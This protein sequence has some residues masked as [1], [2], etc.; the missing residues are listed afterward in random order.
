VNDDVVEQAIVALLDEHTV[1][2]LATTHDAAP[3]AVSLMYARDG[4]AL[5]WVSDPETRHSR[6]LAANPRAAATVARQYEDFT[7]IRGLQMTGRARRLDGGDETAWALDLL[8]ERYPFFERFRA[9][10]AK[11]ARHL[12]AAAAYRFDPETVTLVDNTRGFGF[13]AEITPKSIS[14]RS[15]G[16][17]AVRKCD[18]STT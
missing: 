1:F 12:E 16:R 15:G 9:G 6:D 7:S 18:Q 17:F 13:R 8:T 10:P 11:L 5:V 3:H 14:R 2:T 4:L